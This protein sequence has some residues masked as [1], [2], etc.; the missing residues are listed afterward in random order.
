[1]TEGQYQ[2]LLSIIQD[3]DT[4]L[5]RIEGKLHEHDGQLDGIA[6]KLREHDG[7]FHRIAGKLQEHE[8]RFNGLDEVLDLVLQKVGDV[9][10]RL[11]GF[12][13]LMKASPLWRMVEAV[14]EGPGSRLRR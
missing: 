8:G 7:Q 10:M 2:H 1:M 11:G 3:N 14:E 5:D 12:I 4:K 13:R 6:E 9:D